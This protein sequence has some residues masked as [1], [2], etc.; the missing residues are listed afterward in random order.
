MRAILAT[1]ASS[2]FMDMIGSFLQGDGI[3]GASARSCRV[4]AAIGARKRARAHL[5]GY[6]APLG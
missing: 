4:V 5:R 3:S 2:F 6:N 1:V